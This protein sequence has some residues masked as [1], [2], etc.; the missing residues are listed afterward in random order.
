M[1]GLLPILPTSL[2]TP[3]N[4]NFEAIELATITL[5]KGILSGG[6]LTAGTG[7]KINIAAAMIRG[8]KVCN[9]AGLTNVDFPNNSTK[10]IW[11]NEDNNYLPTDTLTDPGGTY[12]CFGRAVSS[13]G[14][15]T[16]S[17][18]GRMLGF[19]V[20]SNTALKF[21]LSLTYDDV[22]GLVV[23]SIELSGRAKAA[24]FD[25][26][27][28]ASDPSADSGVLK[29]YSK[30]V[31]GSQ[32]LFV[33]D[34]GGT[35]RQLTR[36]GRLN[37]VDSNTQTLSGTKTGLV[38]DAQIQILTP[39]TSNRT[40]KLPPADIHV[41]RTV[42]NG[43]TS[44]VLL[45]NVERYEDNTV[46]A[47]LDPGEFCIVSPQLNPATMAARYGSSYTV[48]APGDNLYPHG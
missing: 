6:A 14:V 40:Y 8:L 27:F 22:N 41:C 4:T 35:V 5:G 44:G 16:V 31:S 9:I 47:S 30:I 38:S 29:L 37:P 28:Q 1:E 17:T 3:F 33:I 20:D 18:I 19:R 13:G 32:E 42:V 21:G 23:P 7:L 26:P 45:I 11:L 25:L 48:H 43:A 12:T 15:V 36:G 39:Q 34:G 24:R 10:Y 2:V 46:V